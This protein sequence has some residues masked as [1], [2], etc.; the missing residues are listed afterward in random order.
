MKIEILGSGCKRCEQLYENALAA[1]ADPDVP[2]GIEVIKVNDV[3]YFTKKGVFMTPGL[4]I[5][6]KVASVGKVLSVE[7]VKKEI[8]AKQP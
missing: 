8:T 4:V 1:A 7:E 5:D 2:D 6:G 3:N